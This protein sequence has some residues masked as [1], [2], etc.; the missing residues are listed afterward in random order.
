[1]GYE[2]RLAAA[3][4]MRHDDFMQRYTAYQLLIESELPLPELEP[5]A[6]S[7]GPADVTIRWGGVERKRP[8]SASGE[9]H[10]WATANEVMFCFPGSAAFMI[11]QGREIII[12]RLAGATDADIRAVLTGSVMAV[13]LHQRGYL[14]LH[15]SCVSKDGYAIA[16]AADSGT[17]KSTLAAAFDSRGY[18]LVADDIVAIDMENATGPRIFPGF[19]QMKLSEQTARFIG[20]DWDRLVQLGLEGEKRGHRAKGKP[21]QSSMALRCV[22]LPADHHCEQIETLTPQQSFGQLINHSYVLSLLSHTHTQSN[23]FRQAARLA[24]TVPV[25]KLHRRR[26]LDLLPAVVTMVENDLAAGSI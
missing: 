6:H 15:A 26:S 2:S 23:H 8:G 16:F 1:M 17:G 4:I 11:S 25:R 3:G 13:L 19:F 21:A 5:A 20:A 18:C 22:Y 7:N 14:I 9:D 24:A 10:I 12:E